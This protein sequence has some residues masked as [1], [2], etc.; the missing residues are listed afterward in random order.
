MKFVILLSL[1]A[2][3]YALP[4][5]MKSIDFTEDGKIIITEPTGKRV[6]IYKNF[7]PTGTKSFQIQVEGPNFPTKSVQIDEYPHK[8]MGVQKN[9]SAGGRGL[10]IVVDSPYFP[11]KVIH[12]DKNHLHDHV[13]YNDAHLGHESD[14]HHDHHYDHHKVYS[15]GKDSSAHEVEKRA[16]KL[17][18]KPLSQSEL[19]DELLKEFQ[20]A[21][22]DKEY[23]KLLSKV[24]KFVKS[25]DLD[26][27][28]YEMLFE[29]TVT[30]VDPADK[31]PNTEISP[32]SP[33]YPIYRDWMNYKMSLV[34]DKIAAKTPFD[35]PL[36]GY[37]TPAY[38][39][40]RPAYGY[41]RPAYGYDSP[42]YGYARP[43]YGY[44][45]S[46]YGPTGAR[47]PVERIPYQ[48]PYQTPY[49][50]SY[51]APYQAPYHASY[52]APYQA[53]YQTPYHYG[54]YSQDYQRTTYEGVAHPTFSRAGTAY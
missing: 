50:A 18:T 40:D 13:H 6:T 20:G 1:V 38:G 24:Y 49:H 17:P 16:S 15:A 27:V 26:P 41:D 12:V 30:P 28:V 19:L 14:H 48:A 54:P 7:G 11:K 29:M 5:P 34:N 33:L 36:V 51:Q 3:S 32:A 35:H 22:T 43:A 9:I 31:K 39:Y 4:F 46:T 2:F 53:Q 52:Q 45:R 10:D 21:I 44:E 42:A 25:G 8:T 37:N 47:T 23:E